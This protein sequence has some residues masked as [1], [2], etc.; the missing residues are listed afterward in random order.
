MDEAKRK[1]FHN[2]RICIESSLSSRTLAS[3]MP[4]EGVQ[5]WLNPSFPSASTMDPRS[6]VSGADANLSALNSVMEKNAK[7]SPFQSQ[8]GG[9]SRNSD[10]LE[11]RPTKVRRKLL[12]LQLPADEY[13][14]TKEG[15]PNQENVSV[16]SVYHQGNSSESSRKPF[17]E[18]GGKSG[19]QVNALR[20]GLASKR[21]DCLADLNEPVQVEETDDS[22]VGGPVGNGSFGGEVL[23][24]D[25]STKP[26]SHYLGFTKEVDSGPASHML[27]AGMFFSGTFVTKS[28]TTAVL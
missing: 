10:V 5:R 22:T 6:S 12:D 16:K 1:E 13:I 9:G 8:N 17:Y 14:D 21:T 2:S 15:E 11:F 20:S 25:L 19:G 3:Q 23:V 4:H 27:E 28:P 26:N 24:K 18:N 7:G